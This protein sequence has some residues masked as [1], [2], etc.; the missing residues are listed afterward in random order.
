MSK[1]LEILFAAAAQLSAEARA[2]AER[3]PVFVVADPED[4]AMDFPPYDLGEMDEEDGE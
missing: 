2:K 4:C 3:E 1:E